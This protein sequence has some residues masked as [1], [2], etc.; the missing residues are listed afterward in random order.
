MLSPPCTSRRFDD[1]L[2]FILP[3]HVA[4]DNDLMVHFEVWD[5]RCAEA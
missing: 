5:Y 4:D 3:G 1:R 2:E